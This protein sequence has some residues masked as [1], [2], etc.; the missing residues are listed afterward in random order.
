MAQIVVFEA[1]FLKPGPAITNASFA[2]VLWDQNKRE[3]TV[4]LEISNQD[5][6][7]YQVFPFTGAHG[8]IEVSAPG[9]KSNRVDVVEEPLAT[10]KE[11][12]LS[13]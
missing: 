12:W 9:F 2:Q 8:K 3:Y 7:I 5:G 11:V 4:P 13:R 10:S 6:N 1:G